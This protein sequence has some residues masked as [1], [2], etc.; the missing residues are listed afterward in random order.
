MQWVNRS[1][2][3]RRPDTDSDPSSLQLLFISLLSHSWLQRFPILAYKERVVSLGHGAATPRPVHSSAGMAE[4]LP[5]TPPLPLPRKPF[6]AYICSYDS[7]GNLGL[8]G[9]AMQLDFKVHGCRHGLL[10][11]AATDPCHTGGRPLWTRGQQ[12]QGGQKGTFLIITTHE[13]PATQ[14]A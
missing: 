11:C 7:G 1:R 12:V 5:L 3:S 9:L 13:R 14:N 4:S 6:G 8:A 10:L 2:R